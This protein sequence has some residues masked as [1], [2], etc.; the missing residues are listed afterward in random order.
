MP[1]FSFGIVMH[2]ALRYDSKNRIIEAILWRL[3][4]R[5][6]IIYDNSNLFVAEKQ[7]FMALV[8]GNRHEKT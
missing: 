2:R 6:D 5:H 7:I 4:R 8:G 3:G 1:S